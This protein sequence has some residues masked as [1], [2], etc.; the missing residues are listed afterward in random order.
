MNLSEANLKHC[1][2]ARFIFVSS[3]EV[4]GGADGL[5]NGSLDETAPLQPLNPYAAA[6]PPPI[7]RSAKWRAMA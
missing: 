4:C 1:P 7:S 3:S 2:V 6:K 5:P